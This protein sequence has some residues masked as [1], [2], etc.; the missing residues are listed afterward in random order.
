[1]KGS[2][3]KSISVVWLPVVLYAV[4]TLLMVFIKQG[5]ASLWRILLINRSILFG[6][7]GLCYLLN[8][9]LRESYRDLLSVLL[10]YAGLGMF[11]KETAVL[12]QLFLPEMDKKL[13][14]IDEQI[15]GFQ[16]A[17][18]FSER[19]HYWW[20]SEMMYFGYFWYYLMPIVV[21]WIIFVENTSKIIEF[22][23]LLI[24]SFVLYY[25]FFIVFPAYGPQFYFPTP[26]NEI[27]AKG[28]FGK[29]VKT[30]QVNGEVPTAAFPSS[31]IGITWVVLIW[32]YQNFR[33][34]ILLFLPLA[35]LLM[36]AT[37]YIK[38]H[39]F[40]DALAGWLSA[41]VMYFVVRFIYKN[42]IVVYVYH[43]K[44]S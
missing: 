7:F 12:N 44:R 22:G 20:F 11:Y 16:P 27:E 33:S 28:I 15:F 21:L 41:F 4:L 31:H 34:Y 9:R 19:F 24:T 38:A 42:I 43:H 2:L 18:V 30:I 8:Y 39:Y 6:I 32:L 25:L 37:V 10:I 23:F 40:V 5:N 26:S 35:I 29:L 36:F 14:I 13:M 17:I 1:M 3:F